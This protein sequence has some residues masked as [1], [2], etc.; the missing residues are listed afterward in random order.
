MRILRSKSYV[1]FPPK[2][3]ISRDL[4]PKVSAQP[5]HY[6]AAP[7]GWAGNLFFAPFDQI[8]PRLARHA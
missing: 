4:K 1:R 3:A 8:E 2:A 6:S 7:A 5:A